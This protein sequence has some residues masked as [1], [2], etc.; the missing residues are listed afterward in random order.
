MCDHNRKDM[1][2]YKLLSCILLSIL[3]FTSCSRGNS[4]HIEVE[5]VEPVSILRFDSLLLEYYQLDD[6]LA[7]QEV[8]KGVGHF[9]PLYNRFILGLNDSPYFLEGEQ[10]I[11][12]DSIAPQLYSDSRQAFVDMSQEAEALAVVTARYLKLFPNKIAPVY[13]AHFSK[14]YMP[15]ITID[16]LVSIS[17]DC[18]LGRD[19][20]LYQARYNN[21]E[22]PQRE[23]S[24]I[25]PDVAE[26]LVRNAIL[27]PS[28]GSLLEQMLYEGRILYL[29]SA[30]IDDDSV[31]RL[32]D[33]TP[34]Q[35]SWCCE[36]E[37]KIW[38]SIV[39]QGD[40]FTYDNMTINKYLRPAPFTATLS[41]DSP[42]RVGRWVGWRI[43]QEYIKKRNFTPFE[44]L[45]DPTPPNE[46]LRLSGYNVR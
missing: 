29:M 20:P 36:N 44:L 21:Y 11:A 34:E 16:S 40:L 37:R 39:E 22:L 3:V 30:L 17:L 42:D 33:Y 4:Y 9:W 45:N 1:K 13:Q 24:C 19:Y 26:V 25:V 35:H 28:E 43:M 15:V 41:Q 10:K 38:V 6:T 12:D 27:A 18:Y 31:E 7:R 46:I 2:N 8:I 5:D 32:L 14:L 23:R